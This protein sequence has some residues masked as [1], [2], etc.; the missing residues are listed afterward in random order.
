MSRFTARRRALSV[1]YEADEK[2]GDIEAL[3]LERL[4]DPGRPTPLPDYAKEIVSGVAAHK[5]EIDG[6]IAKNSSW[7]IERMAVLDRNIMRMAIWE[8]LYG[9]GGPA[10]AYINEAIKLAKIYCGGKSVNFIYGVLCA[11]TGR[12]KP[13]GGNEAPN[14]IELSV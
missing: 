10:V 3:L 2:G 13:E 7:K 1:L 9:E 12:P 4:G 14:S 6:L 11:A 8:C 5:E